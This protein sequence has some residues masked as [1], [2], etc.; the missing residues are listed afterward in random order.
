MNAFRETGRRF[1]VECEYVYLQTYRM[2]SLFAKKLLFVLIQK[3]TKKIKTTRMLPRSL[4]VLH[5]FFAVRSLR[6]LTS[7]KKLN[8][9][10][11]LYAGPPLLSEAR[12]F[13]LIAVRLMNSFKKNF[14]LFFFR[15]PG[16]FG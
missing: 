5:A 14:S 12:A 6:F 13:S 7:P 2:V 4:P 8:R 1:F 9:H 11:R 15:Q 10:S 16:S 3:V